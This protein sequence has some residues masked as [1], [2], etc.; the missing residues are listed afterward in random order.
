MKL[1][2]VENYAPRYI[3][4]VV[5]LVW[6]EEILDCSFRLGSRCKQGRGFFQDLPGS[7]VKA[8]C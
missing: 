4:H 7:G 6:R 2:A 3:P 8:F 5:F 1:H